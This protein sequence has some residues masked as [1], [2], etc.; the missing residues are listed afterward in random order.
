MRSISAD[1][2]TP[3]ADRNHERHHRSGGRAP[4]TKAVWKR[5]A[6]PRATAGPQANQALLGWGRLRAG[7][8]D[9]SAMDDS[10]IR[11]TS[12]TESAGT[13]RASVPITF[14][15]LGWSTASRDIRLI[16]DSSSRIRHMSG[17][18]DLALMCVPEHEIILTCF[19]MYLA[20]YG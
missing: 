18:A 5:P 16:A 20:L 2:D 1:I 7:M 3:F 6:Q 17:D 4:L 15:N 13:R 9:M 19:R 11:Q 14:S 12:G 8:A 10:C